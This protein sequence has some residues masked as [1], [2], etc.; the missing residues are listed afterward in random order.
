MPILQDSTCQN[1]SEEIE[2]IVPVALKLF[3]DPEIQV[4]KK[5]SVGYAPRQEP[6]SESL[7]TAGERVFIYEVVGLYSKVCRTG[8]FFLTVPY[9]RMNQEMQRLTRQ[10]GQIVSVR[11]KI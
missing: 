7:V 11:P 5:Q 6:I 3:V 1:D 8:R 2:I 4:E 9:H 10:G